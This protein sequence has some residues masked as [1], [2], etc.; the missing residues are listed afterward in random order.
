[1]SDRETTVTYSV[2]VP[3]DVAVKLNEKAIEERR[4]PGPMAAILI[5]DSLKN[6]E[7]K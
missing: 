4:K 1:M 7:I 5:E 3:G 6:K 2:R